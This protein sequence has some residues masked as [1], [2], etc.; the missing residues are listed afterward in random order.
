MTFSLSRTKV[1]C[2]GQCLLTSTCSAFQFLENNCLLLNPTYLYRDKTD[3][4]GTDV[5][6][7]DSKWAMRGKNLSC[8]NPG[9]TNAA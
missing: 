6:M 7:E 8:I 1:E 3:T 9:K 4:T 5:Y 2:G